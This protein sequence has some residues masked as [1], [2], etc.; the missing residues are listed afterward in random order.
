MGPPLTFWVEALIARTENGLFRAGQSLFHRLD[1]RIKVLSSLTLVVLSF[2]A[3]DR[4]QLAILMVV[5]V[6]ALPVISAHALLLLRICLM[7]RWLLLFTFLMHLLLSP[8]RTLWGLGWLSLD[9]LYQ[10]SFV[11]LQMVL[12]VIFTAIL[13]I[14]TSIEDLAAAFGWFVRPLSRLGCRT[15]EWQKIL[16]LALGFIPV[17]HAEIHLS[18][19]GDAASPAGRAGGTKGRWSKFFSR[20]EDFIERMLA[21]G[22]KM[23]HQIAAEDSSSRILSEQPSIEPLS[24]L[25][26]YFLGAMI[27]VIVCH[28][29]AG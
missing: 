5:A 11:C 7:L 10:G 12:A 15:D 3:G 4:V 2:A 16:L 25:D 14:T 1:P 13:A 18:G 9:G 27:L 23:A 19:Q 26:R 17:V 22:D 20:T 6:A 28:W 21:R 8:G 29:L 24:L